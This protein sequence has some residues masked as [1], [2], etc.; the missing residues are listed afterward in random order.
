MLC[1]IRILSFF[2]LIEMDHHHPFPFPFPYPLPIPVLIH[3]P[4]PMLIPIRTLH[5]CA[6]VST[7]TNANS[8]KKTSDFSFDMPGIGSALR[9][10]HVRGCLCVQWR[11]FDFL[12]RCFGRFKETFEGVV[13]DTLECVTYDS[14][15][16]CSFYLIRTEKN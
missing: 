12:R 14:I 4:I 3:M 16:E 11:A 9:H 8:R 7:K 10:M 1:G 6:D 13:L 15:Q 2:Q 5:M